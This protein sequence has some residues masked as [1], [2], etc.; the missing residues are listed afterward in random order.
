MMFCEKC[1]KFLPQETFRK[2]ARALLTT[3]PNCGA[4]VQ[5]ETIRTRFSENKKLRTG[6]EIITTQI[7]S[8]KGTI[9]IECPWCGHTRGYTEIIKTGFGDEGDT[10]V[11]CCGKC[12]KVVRRE[13]GPVGWG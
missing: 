9:P 5:Q 4:N 3:C 10:F 2:R 12:R 1:G 11:L 13:G 7:L 6:V 8:I